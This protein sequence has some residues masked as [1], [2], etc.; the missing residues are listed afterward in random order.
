MRHAAP[1]PQKLLHRLN[2]YRQVIWDW[3]GTLVD[4]APLATDIVNGLLDEQGMAA[5]SLAD[6]R[7]AFCHPVETYYRNLGLVEKLDFDTI[8]QRFGLAYRAARDT[9]SLHPGAQPLLA[10]LAQTHTQSLLSASAQ[11]SL[12]HCL[13]HHEIAHCFDHVYGL[14]NHHAACKIDRGHELLA[15][16][17]VSARETVLVGDTDHD[18]EVAAALGVDLI[19]IADGHQSARSLAPLG[20]ELYP[21][22]RALS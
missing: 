11:P 22:W 6:Y 4:D 9:L 15:A 8:C 14:D 21:G 10:R 7:D 13:A 5:T 1:L 18:H 3:N 16:A 20:A 19:L 17:G 2:D 12:E